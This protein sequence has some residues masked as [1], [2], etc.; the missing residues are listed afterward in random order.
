MWTDATSYPTI[1]DA[2]SS[3][4]TSLVI[5][6]TATI[7]PTVLNEF[8]AGYSANHIVMQNV[9]PSQRPAGYN[10]GLFQ[11]GFGG[12]RLPG[13][14]LNGGN[15]YPSGIGLDTGYVPNGPVNSNPSYTYRD[16]VSKIIGKHNLTMGGYFVASQKNEIP[17]VNPSVNG[18]ITLDTSF[19]NS[20]TGTS[21]TGNPFAD[22]LSSN[23]SSFQQASGQGKYYLRYKIFEPYFQDDWR[24]TPRLTLNLGLRISLFGT[25][26]GRLDVPGAGIPY[27]FDPA[28][29]DFT[30]G[31]TVINL[32]GTVGGTYMNPYN[33]LP[34]LNGSFNGI[35]KCGAAG[36]PTGC[37]QGHLFN[38][39]PRLGFAY[40]PFGDGKWAIRGGYGVFFEHTNG[41][42]A[43]ATQLEGSPPGVQNPS[44]GPIGAVF[45]INGTIATSGYSQVGSSLN[46][47]FPE[48]GII[49][50]PQKQIWPYVQQFHFDIEHQLPG[51]IVAIVSYVGSKGTHLGTQSDINQLKSVAEQGLVNPY[52]K[53]QSIGGGPGRPEPTSTEFELRLQ[54]GTRNRPA[55]RYSRCVRRPNECRNVLRDTG[56]IYRWDEW[57][58]SFGPRC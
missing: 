33:T 38:P 3:P 40:D 20:T 15:Q 55:R 35:V 19:S 43:V 18:L 16:N 36:I 4:T 50:L 29:Y 25:I 44:Q 30:P 34:G 10:L 23:L 12:N 11:N 41:N 32:D 5:H 56:S 17:Q 31:A 48:S 9:G 53:G 39:A 51:H 6:L 2:Y 42:E 49:S 46:A 8:V 37:A 47:A 45:N 57:R 14:I 58:R 24:I 21:S 22:L 26:Y 13:V 7:T 52:A 54:L 28:K 27:N 1:Q